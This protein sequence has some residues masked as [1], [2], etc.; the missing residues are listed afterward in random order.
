MCCLLF[1][2]FVV[3]GWWNHVVFESQEVMVVCVWVSYVLLC[4]YW[5][6][7][8]FCIKLMNLYSGLC[9]SMILSS[10]RVVFCKMSLFGM[11]P[12]LSVMMATIVAW[13]TF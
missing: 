13:T 1:L 9:G 12:L 7:I 8:L 11:L 6:A 2:E 5:W 10:L 4:D 3:G